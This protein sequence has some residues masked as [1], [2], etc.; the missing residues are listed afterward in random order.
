MVMQGKRVLTVEEAKNLPPPTPEELEQRRRWLAEAHALAERILER[1][2][3]VPISDEELEWA[4]SPDD[5]DED[6]D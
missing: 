3:G 4:M 1:R 5:E 2:G 6:C